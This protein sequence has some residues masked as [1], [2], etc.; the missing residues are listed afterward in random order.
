[1]NNY[2]IQEESGS[3]NS[4]L[5]ERGAGFLELVNLLLADLPGRSREII[6]RRFGLT[7]GKRETL[8][9]IGGRYDITRER[10]RQ[11]ISE[12][13]K[14]V[15]QKIN[16]P[17]F[18]EA[19]EKIIFT[20]G[21]NNGI[22]KESEIAAKF[23]L[24][25]PA[26]INAVKFLASSSPKI[27]EIEEK[28]VLEKILVVSEERLATVKKVIIE[29]EKIFREEKKLLA[30]EEI[31]EKLSGRGLALTRNEVL[32]H[33]EAAAKVKRNKFGKWGLIHWTE[34][35]PKG[36]REKVYL[37]L[38]EHGKPLHFTDIA[39]LI[40]Q[41]KLGK[42]K[43]HP[44]TVHNELIKDAR[45]VLIGR[46]I[47]ALKEW[48]YF[49]GTIREVLE[50]ILRKSEKPMTKEEIMEQVLKVRRVKKTTVMI[51]LNNGKIFQKQRDLYSV[52]K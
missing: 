51:N 31:F 39:K 26:Q 10:V 50:R 24:T 32:S 37:V 3:N 46:G 33:L 4:R 1:M 52:K 43:A 16:S 34:V 28:G 48:G 22:I 36:T 23:N 41:Y 14:R 15:S 38:K 12:A 21:K 11:I 44:Q 6:R 8:E 20:I 5:R 47:Y 9:G 13:K 25:D 49:A 27:F 18:I 42:R 17:E 30:E 29:T 45:F 40:D 35:S 19:E 2:K 7:G